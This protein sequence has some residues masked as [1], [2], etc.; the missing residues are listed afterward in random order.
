MVKI[1]SLK[2]NGIKILLATLLI[3]IPILSSNNFI[4][5][6]SNASSENEVSDKIVLE[7]E[8][9]KLENDTTGIGGTI[10]SSD[11]FDYYINGDFEYG[12]VGTI[13]D[14]EKGAG[15]KI[16]ANNG[17]PAENSNH[18][19]SGI[20]VTKEKLDFKRSFE[21]TGSA[22]ITGLP[23]GF[24]FGF[25]KSLNDGDKHTPGKN[26]T[27]G[28]GMTN[29]LYPAE[30]IFMEL[31]R[32][33][34]ANGEWDRWMHDDRDVRSMSDES[35]SGAH[36]T[37]VNTTSTEQ[38]WPTWLDNSKKNFDILDYDKN[39][40]NYN[41]EFDRFWTYK[42]AYNTDDDSAVLSLTSLN[43]GKT[44]SYDFNN[45]KSQF[46]DGANLIVTS[47][48]NPDKQ[49]GSFDVPIT[50]FY[51]TEFLYTDINPVAENLGVFSGN[52]S[53][54]FFNSAD[55]DPINQEYF[56]GQ[57]L[58]LGYKVYNSASMNIGFNAMIDLKSVV[59]DFYDGS[60][61][62]SESID[63]EKNVEIYTSYGNS[64]ETI[65]KVNPDNDGNYLLDVPAGN[66]RYV[67]FKYSLPNP[68]RMHKDSKFHIQ[69]T[70]YAMSLKNVW[71][72]FASEY[73]I[74][75]INNNIEYRWDSQYLIASGPM[76]TVSGPDSNLE[77]TKPVDIPNTYDLTTVVENRNLSN[78]LIQGKIYQAK[79]YVSG[80]RYDKWG[81]QGSID[82]TSLKLGGQ[83]V[84]LVGDIAIGYYKDQN[85]SLSWVY[86]S[87][88][89]KQIPIKY[90]DKEIPIV[91]RFKVPEKPFSFD[92]N[93]N[94]PLLNLDLDI[95]R[96][97]LNFSTDARQSFAV[98]GKPLTKERIAHMQP[99]AGIQP[100]DMPRRWASYAKAYDNN[101]LL[102]DDYYILTELP[103]YLQVESESY[104]HFDE[105]LNCFKEINKQDLLEHNMTENGETGLY[106]YAFVVKDTRRKKY[107]SKF[108]DIISDKAVSRIFISDGNPDDAISQAGTGYVIITNKSELT[109]SDTEM[110][111]KA[112][113]NNY[114]TL[115][116]FLI[117]EL[118]VKAYYTD[119]KDVLGTTKNAGIKILSDGGLDLSNPKEG[120][121]TIELGAYDL[122]A[123]ENSQTK[124]TKTVTIKITPSNSWSYDTEDRTEVNGASGYV[125]IPKAI[126]LEKTPGKKELNQKAEVYFAN[127]NS[128]T[129]VRYDMSVDKSFDMINEK[130]ADNKFEVTMSF[131]GG[132]DQGNYLY[133]G[134]INN[135]NKEGKGKIINFTA[136]SEKTDKIKGKWVGKVT[137]YFTRK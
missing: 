81:T 2:C 127:Y 49:F 77:S 46:P 87:S 109:I 31:D 96:M 29:G 33:A 72:P 133:V 22:E 56:S 21:I 17:Q 27:G 43:T 103:S 30:G 79:L 7:Y 61:T 16:I 41:L 23:D 57:D 85:D 6:K 135:T 1:K 52:S 88:E 74:R 39:N 84:E 106:A 101:N 20:A 51:M 35:I 8:N 48:I 93:I 13:Q 90:F 130:D 86:V 128:A 71:S 123:G 19:M 113:V 78:Y 11:V 102:E 75:N 121:Y 62:P 47:A 119:S 67:Y 104:Y 132:I 25:L 44:Y 12:W 37:A 4:F 126:T 76:K 99:N 83:N 115:Q 120:T 118:S 110:S 24:T 111:Y 137:F 105:S 42:I 125:V 131:D 66:S 117:G 10:F 34:N 124:F 94:L 14:S 108:D 15:V 100:D 5:A 45:I 38:G 54:D 122:D 26:L 80:R 60:A 65:S 64:L 129:K 95:N 9:A 36:I 32:R 73:T 50:T 68:N 98:A 112:D 107:D 28:L 59:A 114:T 82:L 92:K 136:S 97:N 53:K 70:F 63:F 91:I 69:P 18:T 40:G 3:I 116:D 134:E 89:Q 55:V 58:V